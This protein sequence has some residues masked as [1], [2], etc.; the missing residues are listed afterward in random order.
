MTMQRIHLLFLIFAVS[1]I[2]TPV[3]QAADK[4]QARAIAQ[5]VYDR[6]DGRDSWALIEM[7][8]ID[9]GG[10]EKVRKLHS[11]TKDYGELSRRFIRFTEPRAIE[12]T[13]FLALE[14]HEEDDVQF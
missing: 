8:L 12:G 1:L 13:S 4:D 14:R 7:T 11:A 10:S 9:D 5:K 2:V 6:D 3:S